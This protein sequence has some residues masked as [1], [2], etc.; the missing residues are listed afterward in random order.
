MTLQKFLAQGLKLLESSV[1]N[2]QAFRESSPMA[3]PGR[4]LGE[5]ILVKIVVA[6][7]LLEVLLEQGTQA[8]I[9]CIELSCRPF[10]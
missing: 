4:L 7:V 3:N 8:G 10:N 5:V 1:A 6:V 2:N 9:S